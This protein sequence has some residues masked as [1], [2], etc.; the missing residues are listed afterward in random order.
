MTTAP[1]VLT[2]AV[3]ALVMLPVLLLRDAA[4]TSRVLS[5]RSVPWSLFNAPLTAKF[6]LFLP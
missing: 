5:L 2:D 4:R 6:R 1:L 3:L